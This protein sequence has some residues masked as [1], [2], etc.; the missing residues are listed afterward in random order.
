MF[1]VHF[2][3]GETRHTNKIEPIKLYSDVDIP[4]YSA[5][6]ESVASDEDII[7][8]DRYPKKFHSPINQYETMS[9]KYEKPK[10]KSHKTHRPRGNHIP[11]VHS[12]KYGEE[13][14]SY[15][16]E[17][18]KYAEEPSIDVEE[19]IITQPRSFVSKHLKNQVENKIDMNNQ[20]LSPDKSSEEVIEE[21]TKDDS[22][23]MTTQL[24][25]ADKQIKDEIKEPMV[26]AKSNQNPDENKIVESHDLTTESISESE[27]T[28]EGKIQD[29]TDTTPD[30]VT[31]TN[32]NDVT[33]STEES[34]KTTIV[35]DLT[36]SDLGGSTKCR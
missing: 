25:E 10:R 21:K 6:M 13:P 29:T 28:S 35:S 5:S 4:T 36:T 26:E 15:Y 27:V 7:I 34:T 32:R 8:Y 31:A 19:P 30:D 24:D 20:Q 14:S 33:V 22:E 3:K 12:F 1:C 23:E 2:Q 18:F 9:Y 16:K 11:K 17:T